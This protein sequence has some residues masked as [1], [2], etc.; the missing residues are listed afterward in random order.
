[1]LELDTR[2]AEFMNHTAIVQ[3]SEIK[4]ELTKQF[5]GNPIALVSARVNFFSV[6]VTVLCFGFRMRMVL[7]IH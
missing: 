3:N 6:A 1:M 7:I 5:F 4:R 2:N